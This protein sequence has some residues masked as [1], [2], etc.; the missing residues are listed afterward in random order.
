MG[1][2][3]SVSISIKVDDVEVHNDG[4]CSR[5]VRYGWNGIAVEFRRNDLY[6]FNDVA[7][8][9]RKSG[10]GNWVKLLYSTGTIAAIDTL[11]HSSEVKRYV[12][13]NTGGGGYSFGNQIP[14]TKD[15]DIYNIP[16]DYVEFGFEFDI[17][18]GI[19]WPY[20][21]VFWTAADS[22]KTPVHT[23]LCYAG[24]GSLTPSVTFEVNGK[25]VFSQ[26]NLT[27]Q[28][29]HYFKSSNQIC[30][31]TWKTWQYLNNCTRVYAR[32]DTTS[33]WDVVLDKAEGESEILIDDDYVEFGFEFDIYLGT[34]WPYSDVFW[35]AEDSAR[36]KVEYIWI[37][38]SGSA[39]YAEIYIYVND[40]KVVSQNDLWSQEQHH[41]DIHAIKITVSHSGTFTRERQV[42]SAR[43]SSGAEVT[44]SDSTGSYTMFVPT[45]YIDFGYTV[46][47]WLVDWTRGFWFWLKKDHPNDIV[48]EITIHTGG[49]AIFGSPTVEYEVKGRK[50]GKGETVTLYHYQ[51]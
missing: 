32:K 47:F 33:K 48:E 21:N 15:T 39:R 1:G 13:H 4:N 16:K 10:S 23:I 20:S 25:E 9:G 27:G 26:S 51:S 22:A 11:K 36:E 19:S 44:L 31:R 7:F 38:M 28:R 45:S 43:T 5:H 17:V 12:H 50:D 3:S 2:A 35:T 41:W 18:S 42:V 30:V 46:K 40:K 29:R 49:W 34:N 14:L 8:Y 37:E 24:G 6:V